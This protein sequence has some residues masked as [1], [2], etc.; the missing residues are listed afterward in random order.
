V[1]QGI[2]V[3]RN[4]SGVEKVTLDSETGLKIVT[5]V[6][7][8]VI[9]GVDVVLVAPGREPNVDSTNFNPNVDGLNL[10]AATGVQ[11]RP[12]KTIVVDEMQQTGCDNIVALGD[13][14][15]RVELTPMA[16]AGTCIC[17]VSFDVCVYRVVYLIESIR[18]L[19]PN[20]SIIVFFHCYYHCYYYHNYD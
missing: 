10:Q 16:I 6:S 1:R 8:D 2:I 11:Q 3:H 17:I 13:V 14:C 7:G 12:N 5:C 18:Q 15:G 9:T 19:T 4:T 20:S